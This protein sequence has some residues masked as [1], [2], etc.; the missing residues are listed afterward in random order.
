M[1][2]II[3]LPRFDKE[4]ERVYRYILSYTKSEKITNDIYNKIIDDIERLEIFP[5]IGQIETNLKSALTIRSL[6]ILKNYKVY[7]F[8]KDEIIFVYSIWDCRRDP[9]GLIL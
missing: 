4:I 5:T 2:K 6:I 7:Y 1:T 9:K 3:S 8:I